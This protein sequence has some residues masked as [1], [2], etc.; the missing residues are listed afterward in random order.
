MQSMEKPKISLI[1]LTLFFALFFGLISVNTQALEAGS[2]TIRPTNPDPS[3]PFGKSWFIYIAQIGKEIRDQVDVI[4]LTNASVK[5]K[6]WA[7]DAMTTVDGAYTIKEEST[8]IGTWINFFEKVI[9]NEREETIDLGSE[10]IIDLEANET[11]TLNFKIVVPENAEVGDHMGAIMVQAVDGESELL[12]EKGE[13]TPG[14]KVVTRVGT[15]VFLTVPGEIIT[16]LEFLKFSW[17]I[18]ESKFYF[19]LTLENKGN[20]RIEPKGEIIIKNI[21]GTKI[22]E[23][24]IPTR[25]VFPKGKIVIPVEWEN[26]RRSFWLKCGGFIAEAKVIYGPGLELTQKLRIFALSYYLPIISAGIILMIILF[27]ITKKFLKPREKKLKREIKKLTRS[28]KKA[29]FPIKFKRKK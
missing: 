20:V 13:I 1:I 5:A 3:Q 16:L 14:V 15:R 17:E 22:K 24:E 28:L 29:L 9:E 4:N 23:L 26:W 10:I 21:L 11:K 27:L 2:L 19:F 12:N 8:D 18:K 7:V 6:V 25:I